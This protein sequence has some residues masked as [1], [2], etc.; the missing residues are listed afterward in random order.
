MEPEEASVNYQAQ[1]AQE[2]R[3]TGSFSGLLAVLHHEGKLPPEGLE[4]ELESLAQR[5]QRA[6]GEALVARGLLLPEELARAWA[7]FIGIPF[8]PRLQVEGV[9]G[10][11]LSQ[12]PI[13]FARKHMLVPVRLAEDRLWVAVADPLNMEVVDDLRVRTGMDV[14]PVLS[15]EAEITRTIN[16][17]Y[18]ESG[19]SAEQVLAHLGEM[20]AGRS[21]GELEE[22]EDL[23]E[24]SADAPVIKLVNTIL[25]EAV[26][27]R[28]SDIHIEPYQKELKIRYR[29]DGVLYNSLTPSRNL[30]S[31][32]VSRIKVM[33]KMNIAE[34][35]LPQDGRIRLKV[36]DRDFDIRVSTLPTSFGERVVL[37][38]LDK[39]SVLLGLEEVGLMPEQM[40]LFERL[41]SAPN[42]IVL[43]TG[44]TGSGKTTT[45][46]AA[47]NRINSPDKNIIT[48]EDPVEYQLPGIGQI[49]VNTKIGLT[50]ARGLRS[51]V[52]QDPDV[53]LV[54]EIRDTE[55]AEI[56]IHAAL[57]GHLVFSTL[58]TNDAAGAITRLI[59]MGIEPFLVSSSV[60]AILAQRLVRVICPRCKEGYKPNPRTMRELGIQPEETDVVLYRG[61]GCDACLQTGFRGRTGIFEFLVMDDALRGL[62]MQT[63]DAATLRR[64]AVER[65]MRTLRDDGVRKIRM[66]ITTVEEVLR[67]T[68]E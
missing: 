60:N 23:L 38:L 22:S 57:T 43:V 11:V 62:M 49:Q 17:I 45:L 47:L 32:I 58:H 51:I 36:A 28:A 9:D 42:G 13:H 66:G 1:S 41:I 65:G 29:V 25:S 18:H 15:L 20:G 26:R 52:R 68:G 14:V 67:V 50:F 5:D 44:P 8:W 31:A 35:R 53:I 56:S 30:H 63:S 2:A 4:P 34:K 7:T 39:T 12:I 37:R 21:L 40:E 46:Y 6:L 54:G 61:R 10:Y 3:R 24:S 48:I 59:D 16:R 33:A 27:V 19:D 64:S 55:T